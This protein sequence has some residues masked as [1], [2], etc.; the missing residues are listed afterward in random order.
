MHDLRGCGL[1]SKP[2]VEVYDVKG[3]AYYLHTILSKLGIKRAVHIGHSWGGGISLQYYFD[4][5]GEVAGIIFIGSYSA[6]SQLSIS[7]ADVLKLYSTIQGRQQ[8]FQTLVAHEKF[9]KYNPYSDE[10]GTRAR[11][12]GK[13]LVRD[14]YTLQ[15]QYARVSSA[16][17]LQIAYLR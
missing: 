5:P 16:M 3:Q 7:E 1:S 4:Y 15:T 6:G 14:Q 17:I 9:Y 10:I 2:D 12:C 11:C 8:V 13:K